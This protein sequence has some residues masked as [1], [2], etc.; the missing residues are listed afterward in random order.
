MQMEESCIL[1]DVSW[2]PREHNAEA[3]AITNDVVHWLDPSKQ[4]GTDL[5]TLPCKILHELL[6]KGS[7]FTFRRIRP[8]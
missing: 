6:A 2:L 8:T 7:E 4:V 1:L 5:A 3:G